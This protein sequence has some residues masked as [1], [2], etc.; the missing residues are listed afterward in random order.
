MIIFLQECYVFQRTCSSNF[1]VSSNVSAHPAVPQYKIVLNVRSSCSLKKFFPLDAF[2][3]SGTFHNY[4]RHFDIHN[5]AVFL[6]IPI[7]MPKLHQIIMIIVK[8]NRMMAGNI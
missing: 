7:P 4:S 2:C 8:L 6:L 5:G 1:E 3:I